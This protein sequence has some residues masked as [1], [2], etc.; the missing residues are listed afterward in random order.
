MSRHRIIAKL[1]LLLL[2]S[3]AFAQEGLK[4]L[5]NP[6]GGQTRLRA[7]HGT[8]LDAGRN[9]WAFVLRGNVHSRFG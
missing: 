3:S 8:D 4:T 2:C 5:D 7:N 9:G 6:G 1:T